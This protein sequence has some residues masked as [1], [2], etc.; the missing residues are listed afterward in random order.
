[1]KHPLSQHIVPALA[2]LLAALMLPAAVSAQSGWQPDRVV[3]IV[4]G[5]GAGSGPDRM[6]RSI[7]EILQKKKLIPVATS[8]MNRTGGGGAIGWAYL[9]THPGDGHFI[10]IGAGN[11]SV[12][13]LTGAATISHRDLS[14]IAMLFHE[15]I[16]LSVRTDSPIKDGR[17][18]LARLRADPGG[19]SIAVSSVAGS[20]THIAA[21]LAL[22]AGGVDIKKMRTVVFK[23]AGR[24]LSAAMGGHVDVA[25]GSM[26]Q[27]LAQMRTGKMRIIG[28]T[29]PRRLGGALAQVP[30]WREQGADMQFSNYRGI[31]GP[32]GMTPAQL[33]YWENVFAELDKDESWRADLEKNH[34]DRDFQK[35]ED[36]GKYLD[37]LSVPIRATLEDL[38]LLK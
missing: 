5:T 23:S 20:A 3:E 28:Y 10:M 16:A 37:D 19:T 7:Q 25:A 27:A 38:G 30:T 34:L 32:K 21:A 2:G 15:Y 33:R 24:S 22:K 9:N 11:L 1:M 8:V 18:L 6:A 29:A 36:M 26:S 31:V 4:V 13:H 12:A 17:D 14:M 35:S